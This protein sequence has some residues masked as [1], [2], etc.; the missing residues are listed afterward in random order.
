MLQARRSRFRVPMRWILFNWPNLSSRS[1]ALGSTQPVTEM[2]TR[3]LSAGKGRPARKHDNLTAICEPI[4]K[5]MWE[6]R[7]LTILWAFTACYRDSITKYHVIRTYRRVKG[8]VQAF[9]T[10]NIMFL[11]ISIDLVSSKTPSC[12]YLKKHNVSE[13]GT[14]SVDWAQ[15]S[16]FYLWTETESSLRNIVFR[17][18]NR[19]VF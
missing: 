9:L 8:Y 5:K 6:P 19:T 1:V 16:R 2:S 10:S 3:N 7:P 12:L 11:D 17:N 18:I 13:I 4:V 15:V 14:S